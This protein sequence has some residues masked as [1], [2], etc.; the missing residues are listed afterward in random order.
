MKHHDQKQLG[1]ASVYLAYTSRLYYIIEE[2]QE[3]KSDTAGTQ[4]Q[5][6][7][8]RLWKSAAY[9]LLLMACSVCLLVKPGS[10]SRHGTSHSGLDSPPSIKLSSRRPWLLLGR[11]V[12]F[13]LTGDNRSCH[14]VQTPEGFFSEKKKTVNTPSA[15]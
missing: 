11:L 8:Q 12:I 6:L 1:R 15:R 4:R 3:M 14:L 2:K 10:K 5:K 7:M 9:P 13:G